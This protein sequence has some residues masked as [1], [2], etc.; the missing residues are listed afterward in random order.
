ML[1]PYTQVHKRCP[2][3]AAFQTTPPQLYYQGG[4]AFWE[5]EKVT[6]MRGSKTKRSYRVEWKGGLPCRLILGNLCSTLNITDAFKLFVSS[7][8]FDKRRGR[9]SLN[10]H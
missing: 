4:D 10:P 6:A 3:R 9:R 5:V 8:P 7:L 1:K 2:L